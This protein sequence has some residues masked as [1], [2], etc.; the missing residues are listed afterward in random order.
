MEVVTLPMLLGG[1]PSMDRTGVQQRT[2]C[3]SFCCQLLHVSSYSQSESSTPG[4]VD[5]LGQ[6]IP[7]CSTGSEK[8]WSEGEAFS[9]ADIVMDSV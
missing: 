1:L 4:Q 9:D 5:L 8:C 3:L 6:N 2:Q 7:L